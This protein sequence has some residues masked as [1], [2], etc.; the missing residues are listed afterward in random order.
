MANKRKII[1]AGA[2]IGGLTAALAL[3]KQGF[4]VTVCEQSACFSEVGAGLQMGPNAM[5]VLRALA[6]TESLQT[7]AFVPQHACIRHYKT[8]EYYLKTP[9]AGSIE[10][11]YGAPYWHL[12][13]ADL[14]TVLVQACED[15]GVEIVLNARLLAYQELNDGQ[16]V[17]VKLENGWEMSADLLVA[18]DGVKSLVRHQ[19][20]GEDP[21]SFTGQVAWRGLIPV[22]D[23]SGLDIQPDACVWAGP[24]RHFVSYYLRGG[25]FVN[26]V[27]VE[28]REAW[29]SESWREEGDVAILQQAFAGWHPQVSELLKCV[30]STFLWSLNGRSELPRWHQNGVVLLG[31]ACHPM[32]PFMAQGAAMAIE[33]AYILAKCLGAQQQAVSL[34][35]ALAKYEAMRKPRATQVQAMSRANAG[36]FHMH[37]GPFGVLKLKALQQVS[38]LMPQVVQKKLDFVYGY[39]ATQQ[40]L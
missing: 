5:H 21:A 20:L 27:A 12:H 35:P 23:L 29:H 38:H 6:L 37:G 26:F 10:E 30:K 8:G 18:A 2:G 40:D 22:E 15:A 13:R 19:M 39:D 4:F 33:D 7:A 11:K 24:G 17:K 36:L 28:E 25:K 32:L 31:D 1:V 34:T 14:H 16:G 9:L 3:A